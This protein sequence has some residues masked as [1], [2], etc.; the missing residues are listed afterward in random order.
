MGADE[1]GTRCADGKPFASTRTT[2]L[3]DRRRDEGQPR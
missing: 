3:Y 1:P 2:P